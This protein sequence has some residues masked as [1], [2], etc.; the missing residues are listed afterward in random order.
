MNGILLDTSVVIA[1]EKGKIDLHAWLASQS[2][3][4]TSVITSVTIS[5][6][7]YGV[8]R[9]DTAARARMRRT[10]TDEFIDASTVLDFDE[11]CARIHATI[12]SGLEACGERIGAHDMLIAA[13]ALRHNMA[14]ATL[15]AAEFKRVPKL[16]VITP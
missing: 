15:N 14:V 13:T 2:A 9:A 10:W 7:L 12:W 11:E 6:L 16:K 5:E 1:F 8:E 3:D 4:S